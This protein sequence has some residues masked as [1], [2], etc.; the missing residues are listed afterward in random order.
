LFN[1]IDDAGI[2]FLL[3]GAMT[4]NQF[5]GLGVRLS[6]C[7]LGLLAYSAGAAAAD[8]EC[9]LVQARPIE[10]YITDEEAHRGAFPVSEVVIEG[11][12]FG[13]DPIVYFGD[14]QRR[15]DVTS[16]SRNNGLD[17]MTL[18]LPPGT[19]S[20][21]YKVIVQNT[22]GPFL[23]NDGKVNP[24]FCFGSFTIQIVSQPLGSNSGPD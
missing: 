7:V 11:I 22:T 8:Y 14:D 5:D 12:N 21:T 2:G 4:T 6:V 1:R 10:K 15:A 9:M 23:D 13:T 20:G 17:S 19:R 3:E 24:I 18:K 16:V